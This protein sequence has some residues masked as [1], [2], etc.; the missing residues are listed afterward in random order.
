[1]SVP[2]IWDVRWGDADDNR[3]SP[4]GAGWT[5]LIF[6]TTMEFGY[7]K[8]AIG[9]LLLVVLPALLIGIAPSIL[10]T[11]GRI[12]FGA[13]KAAGR[14]PTIIALLFLAGLV[15][16]ALWIGRPLFAFGIDNFWHLHYTIVV[17]IF[18]TVR[19][20]F[21]SIIER[22]PGQSRT[23]ERLH[24]GRRL[25][26]ILAAMLLGGAGLVLALSI[27]FTVGFHVVDF[28]AAGLWLLGRTILADAA[29]V[30]AIST[31]ATSALWLWRELTLKDPVL[32]WTPGSPIPGA[33]VHRVAHLSDLHLVGERY[34]YRMETGT[35]GPQGNKSIGDAL[36]KLAAVHEVHPV[37]R[38]LVTGDVTDAG[39]RAEW[40]EFTDLVKRFPTLCPR[41]SFVPGN[42]DVNI[43]DRTNTGRPDLPWS[44]GQALR[45]LRVILALDDV[46]GNRAHV[47]D[48]KSG[49]IGPTL[50]D[51]L[52][53]GKRPDLLREL[54]QRGTTRG[55]LE[56]ARIWREA[57]PLVEP[58]VGDDG[59]GIVLLNSNARTHFSITNAIG[60][61]DRAQLRALRR[62]LGNSFTTP[63]LI[64]LHHAVVEYP[65]P[66][67]K[68]TDRIALALMNAPEVLSTIIP[69]ADRTII[70]HGH[71]HRDW[72]GTIGHIAL[73]S[74]PSVSL[75][76]PLDRGRFSIH[77]FALASGGDIRLTGSEHVQVP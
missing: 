26:A 8:A 73:C 22:F 21:R 64:L 7:V 48:R 58:P 77:E 63:W 70:L 15:L 29:M 45:R 75:A 51:Y 25:G 13:L 71:R 72:T 18:V 9:F 12:T 76:Q 23:L 69:H 42:H 5:R 44:V 41:L 32:E 61:V 17:P 37:D 59:Y 14:E 36:R 60:V 35:H 55:R 31:V 52:R 67:V 39:I 6:S 54:A 43:V 40:A 65:V 27:E 66:R 47:V 56:M 20:V 68:L 57:F 4:Y 11:Y 24:N 49:A 38:V 2:H 10:L 53:Q 28:N 46:Q 3:T 74:A 34:G 30:F 62:M 1:M 33:P 19:E 16:L 50:T